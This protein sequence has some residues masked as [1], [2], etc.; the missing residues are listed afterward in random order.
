MTDKETL[1]ALTVGKGRAGCLIDILSDWQKLSRKK[2]KALLDRRHVFVNGRRVWIAHHA[3]KVGDRIEVP[4]GTVPARRAAS[5]LPPENAGLRSPNSLRHAGGQT[6]LQA[7]HASAAKP[8]QRTIPEDIVLLSCGDGSL[9][10]PLRTS[11]ALPELMAVH[12]LDRDTSGCIIYAT[13]RAAFDRMVKMFSRF[14]IR[15]QYHVIVEG[16]IRESEFT[17]DRELEGHRAISHVKVVHANAAGNASCPP[18]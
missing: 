10:E 2:A 12:R 14:E 17:I 8:S 15:K 4:A 5:S 3:V 13:G 9:E 6:A 11:L 1:L 16:L 18:R 7:P